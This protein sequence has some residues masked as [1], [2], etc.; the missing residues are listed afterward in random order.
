MIPVLFRVDQFKEVTAVFPTIPAD[1]NGNHMTCYAHIGQH[2]GCSRGWYTGT[3]AATPTEWH[4]LFVEL[5]SIGY[6]DMKPV[7][8]ISRAMDQERRALAAA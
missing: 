8:R 6:D 3:R 4:D 7:K 1:V 5:V 2:S